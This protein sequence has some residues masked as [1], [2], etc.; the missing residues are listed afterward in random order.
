MR[1]VKLAESPMEM[2]PGPVQRLLARKDGYTF[3]FGYGPGWS[4]I[5]GSEQGDIA[6]QPGQW[7]VRHDDGTITV[8]D[9]APV[10][11]TCV[12]AGGSPMPPPGTEP[13]VVHHAGRV[14]L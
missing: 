3:G 8:Q 10:A 2:A 12:Y 11:C 5:F 7:V 1:A 13:C 14:G 4:L 6:V 9:E